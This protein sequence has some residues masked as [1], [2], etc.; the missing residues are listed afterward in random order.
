MLFRVDFENPWI[1][2]VDA[3]PRSMPIWAFVPGTLILSVVVIRYAPGIAV[4]ISMGFHEPLSHFQGNWPEILANVIFYVVVFAPLTGLALVGGVIEGRKTWLPESHPARAV[5]AGCALGV[6]GFGASIGIAYL[7]GVVHPGDGVLVGIS[8]LWPIAAGAI[9]IGVQAGAEEI[10]FRGWIQ[11]IFCSRWG[12][13]LGVVVGALCFSALHLVA[14]PRGLVAVA[15][16]FLSGIM[17]GVL[18]LRSGG[19]WAAAAM[20]WAWNWT[21]SCGFGANPNPGLGPTGALMD[22]DLAGVQLWSGGPDAMNGSLA[23]TIVLSVIVAMLLMAP[24]TFRIKGG[25]SRR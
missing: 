11:P 21:E 16:F 9:M 4:A 2:S 13:F 17:F 15:N 5:L 23:T 10:Y 8:A 24:A 19:I 12:P 14:G 3:A 1:E 22:M 6:A 18:A 25:F 7:V 20:H